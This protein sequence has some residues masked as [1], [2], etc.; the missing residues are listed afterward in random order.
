M[1]KGGRV[2]IRKWILPVLIVLVTGTLFYVGYRKRVQ[3]NHEHIFF[4]L[5]PYQ[6]NGGWGYLI[7]MNKHL[8]IRQNIIPAVSGRRPF[9][10]REDALAVGQLVFDRL[11]AGEV[12]MVTGSDLKA[13]GI[14]LDSL[15]AR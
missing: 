3:W 14:R 12:P 11:K 1:T 15:P 8:Y 13:M 5:K 9:H 7:F 4:E 6:T 2:A 10:S